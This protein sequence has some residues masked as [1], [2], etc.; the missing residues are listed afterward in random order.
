MFPDSP[1]FSRP[2]IPVIDVFPPVGGASGG[3]VRPDDGQGGSAAP[4]KASAPKGL[5]PELVRRFHALIEEVTGELMQDPQ[6]DHDT[7]RADAIALLIATCEHV[8]SA[9]EP[10][11]SPL[12]Y[13]LLEEQ[14]KAVAALGRLER[15][16]DASTFLRA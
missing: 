6:Q 12:Q 14:R 11:E 9:P 1:P 15:S 2:D 8:E 16:E 7:C 4:P 5:S 3:G 13:L 10:G